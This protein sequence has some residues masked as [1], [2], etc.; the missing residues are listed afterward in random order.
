MSCAHGRS[1]RRFSRAQAG[2]GVGER[3]KA[4]RRGVQ[5]PDDEHGESGCEGGRRRRD[6]GNSPQHGADLTGKL[7][8]HR[9][10]A[11]IEIEASEG[12]RTKRFPYSYHCGAFGCTW[13]VNVRARRARVC[14]R[15]CT[16]NSLMFKSRAKKRCVCTPVS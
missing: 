6:A 3:E 8:N 10:G 12:A 11:E 14:T 15:V 7:R 9:P 13:C 16:F 5:T 1:E 2:S 4:A